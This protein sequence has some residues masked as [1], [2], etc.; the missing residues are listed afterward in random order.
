MLTNSISSISGANARGASRRATSTGRNA[1]CR[2]SNASPA[3]S[4]WMRSGRSCMIVLRR[5][6]RSEFCQRGTRC[7]RCTHSVDFPSSL[8]AAQE[9]SIDTEMKIGSPVP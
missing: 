3:S 4:L 9:S 5:T 7:S 2:L 1:C 8:H 6:C